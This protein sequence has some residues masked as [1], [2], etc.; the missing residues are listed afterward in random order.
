MVNIQY[1]RIKKFGVV[2][3]CHNTNRYMCLE[4]AE[5]LETIPHYYK[6]KIREDLEIENITDN[7]NQDNGLKLKYAWKFVVHIIKITMPPLK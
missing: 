2:E 1:E 7:L 4:D 5:V 3:H 6:R